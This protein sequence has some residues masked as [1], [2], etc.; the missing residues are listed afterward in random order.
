MAA[1]LAVLVNPLAGRGRGATVA[2][3]VVPHLRSAGLRVMRLQGRDGEEAADLAMAAVDD[4][5]DSLV[6]VGGDGTVRLGAQAVA[7]RGVPLGIIP[8]GTGNDTA[9]SLGIDTKHPLTAADVVIVGRCRTVDLAEVQGRVFCTVLATGLDSRVNE[10]ANAMR[11][12]RGQLRYSLATLAEL[13]TL[14]PIR[15]ALRLDGTPVGREAMLVAVGNGPSYGGG[16]RMCAG[17]DLTDG[18]LDVVIIEPLGR[19]ELVALYPRLFR[20][21][22][23]THRSYERHRVRTVR[24]DAPGVVAYADGERIGPL[25]MTV[26]TRPGAL[27]VYAPYSAAHDVR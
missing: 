1:T 26:S 17:A 6:V 24:L 18:L 11:W 23:V 27:Q 20:G 9:R 4:G 22:H 10:R 16:L 15:Y 25:P 12:P 19:P 14:Q 13:R 5:V 2:E 7:D 3:A 21:T 8:A